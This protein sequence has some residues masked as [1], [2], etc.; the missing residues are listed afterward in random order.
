MKMLKSLLLF[1][2]ACASIAS[3]QAQA[4]ADT[5]P[6]FQPE[7]LAAAERI[8]YAMGL[9]E[10]FIIP[11]SEM[12]KL[13]KTRDPVNAGLMGTV[14]QPYLE[15]KYTA[16]KLRTYFASRFDPETC[17]QIA[18]FWE[19]P[20]GKKLVKTQVR[21]LTTGKAD[22]PV[23]NRTE[24]AI[25]KKFEASAAGQS[26]LEAMPDIEEVLSEYTRDTQTKMREEFLRQLER[27]LK[28]GS[29]AAVTPAPVQ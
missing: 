22:R 1:L 17:L 23:Y 26:M 25:L 15:K 19:G 29:Q 16:E 14:F 20:V 4:P 9:P 27:R 11:T 6:V 5:P 18:T 2:L 21:L 24:K 8:V 7:H 13:S 28:N 12:I 10:R 3:A